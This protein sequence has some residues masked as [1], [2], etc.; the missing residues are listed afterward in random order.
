MTV[1]AL[2]HPAAIPSA[3]TPLLPQM[4]SGMPRPRA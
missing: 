1:P 4:R 2:L 3:A